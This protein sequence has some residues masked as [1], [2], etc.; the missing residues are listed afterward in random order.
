MALVSRRAQSGP[1]LY[2]T[3]TCATAA[4]AAAGTLPPCGPH[5]APRMCPTGHID[6]KELH[7]GLLLVYDKLNKVGAAHRRHVP[8]KT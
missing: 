7:V 8:A 6:A 3:E 2:C 4:A 1:S 5:G